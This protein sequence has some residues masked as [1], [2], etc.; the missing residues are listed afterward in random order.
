MTWLVR[1]NI[2]IEIEVECVDEECAR[3]VV[4]E[5]INLE[6][7]HEIYKPIVPGGVVAIQQADITIDEVEEYD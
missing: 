1:G 6:R 2:E 5:K 3:E 4:K 7:I